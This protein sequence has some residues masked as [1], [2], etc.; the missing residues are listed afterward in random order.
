MSTPLPHCLKRGKMAH[1]PAIGFAQACHRL[2]PFLPTKTT[3]PSWPRAFPS[4]PAKTSAGTRISLPQPWHGLGHCTTGPKN[5]YGTFWLNK[6]N[7]GARKE[8]LGLPKAIDWWDCFDLP[9]VRPISCGSLSS[10]CTKR[11]WRK[12][13][14]L[15]QDGRLDMTFFAPDCIH[16]SQ[17][18]HSQLS[19]ALWAN[20]VK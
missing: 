7:C 2:G 10:L 18:S 13:I 12:F 15:F 20:M 16:P 8:G 11:I 6:G 14:F 9:G 17:K 4:W 3:G 5:R 1:C 19:R